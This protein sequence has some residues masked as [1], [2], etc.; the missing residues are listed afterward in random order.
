MHIAE[1][2]RSDSTSQ[3]RKKVLVTTEQEFAERAFDR[4]SMNPGWTR[5]ARPIAI[6]TPH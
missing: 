6:A 3:A 4:S 2:S 5:K 1:S